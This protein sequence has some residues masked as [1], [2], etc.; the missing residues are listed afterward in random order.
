MNLGS[1]S[2]DLDV[3]GGCKAGGVGI[4]TAVVVGAGK[5][6]LT[7]AASARLMGN[8][9]VKDVDGPWRTWAVA[10]EDVGRVH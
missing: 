8:R 2:P 10:V 7:L 9:A 3:L 4:R 5:I 1:P 6:R